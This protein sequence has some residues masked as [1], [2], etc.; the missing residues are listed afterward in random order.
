MQWPPIVKADNA[1]L[2]ALVHWLERSQWLDVAA[3]QAGQLSQLAIFLRHFERQSPWLQQRAGLHRCTVGQL[4]QSLEAF[5]QFPVTTRADVQRAG[6]NFHSRVVP[7]AHKPTAPKKTS[8]S[9]GEPVM[10]YRTAVNQLFWLATTLREHLWHGRDSKGRLAIVRANLPEAFDL[11]AWGSPVGDLFESGP[12]YGVPVTTDTSA[13]VAWL[14]LK[15]PQYLLIYPGVWHAVLYQL[16]GKPD[17]PGL[18]QVRTIGETL[19]DALRSQT[20]DKLGITIADT[21]SSEEVGVIAIECPHSGL[22]HTMAEGL[23]VE[24]LRPDGQPCKAGEVGRVVVT[25]LLNFASPLV[26]YDIGDYAEPGPVCG[27]G[28]G[29]PTLKRV[30]GRQRGMVKLPDGRS[31]WP[32]TGFRDF[33]SVANITQYQLVQKSMM[34]RFDYQFAYYPTHIPKPASGKFEEFVC[35]I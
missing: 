27:C 8:G 26:R 6:T 34:H 18:V 16:Q 11:P 24:V 7:P 30:L 3:L 20:R 22:Y 17:L 2:V 9:T 31:H 32:L 13:L 28:R 35:E 23:I 15:Q 33:S 29:L 21:Y 10:V 19:S 5:R 12:F 4:C 25:D 1:Q 14:R